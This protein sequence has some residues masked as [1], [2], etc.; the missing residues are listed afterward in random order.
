MPRIKVITGKQKRRR[1]TTEDKTRFVA[2]AMHPG[3]TVSLVARQHD[4]T[5]ILL[6]KWKRL[7]NDGGKAG[8]RRRRRGCQRLRGQSA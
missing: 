8:Y 1:Y 7:M 5:S 3:Y 6:F 2:L 4:I